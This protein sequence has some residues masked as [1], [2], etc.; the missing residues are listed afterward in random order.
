MKKR[1]F[2]KILAVFLLPI[3]V[4]MILLGS[5]SISVLQS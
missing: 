3:M 2:L 5:L 4:P 1:F